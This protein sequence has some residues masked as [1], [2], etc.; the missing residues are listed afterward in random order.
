MFGPFRARR[1]S[2]FAPPPRAPRV[3]NDE[4]RRASGIAEPRF[5]RSRAGPV[6]DRTN[7]AA[8]DD[9]AARRPAGPPQGPAP[10][11]VSCTH[12]RL[13]RNAD[14]API[15]ATAKRSHAG[16]LEGGA[17][18]AERPRMAWGAGPRGLALEAFRR[19]F[20]RQGAARRDR[21]APRRAARQIGTSNNHSAAA[22]RFSSRDQRASVG[23]AQHVR[24]AVRGRPPATNRLEAGARRRPGPRAADCPGRSG[25]RL[26]AEG[27]PSPFR[28]PFDDGRL[29]GSRRASAGGAPAAEPSAIARAPPPPPSPGRGMRPAEQRPGTTGDAMHRH[30]AARRGGGAAETGS[31]RRTRRGRRPPRLRAGT[32]RSNRHPAA[33]RS[34]MPG[35]RGGL[36]PRSWADPRKV[37]PRAPRSADSGPGPA[38]PDRPKRQ[39]ARRRHAPAEAALAWGCRS[40]G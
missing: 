24:A 36:C 20:G 16:R 38:G 31:G 40:G 18:R 19:G 6:G 8:D 39:R 2:R 9:E 7:W 29:C 28:G 27:E 11:M 12:R 30:R 5:K 34:A 3:R 33:P 17:G 23:R 26:S 35:R 15:S 37:P 32:R 13:R 21:P 10:P 4:G 1:P 25:P 22:A 14:E